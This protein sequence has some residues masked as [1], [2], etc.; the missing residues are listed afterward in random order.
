MKQIVVTDHG[1]PDLSIERDVLESMNIELIDADIETSS[2]M[3]DA[4]KEADALLNQYLSIPDEVL[5]GVDSLKV[6]GRYGIGVDTVNVD[7]ATENGIAVINVPDYCV[8]EVA[9]HALS[10]I[11]ACSRKVPLFDRAVKAGEWEWSIGR[12]IHRIRGSTLGIVAFGNIGRRLAE[13]VEGFDVDIIAF[14][15]YQSDADLAAYGVRK[16]T[17]TELLEQSDFISVHA[18]LTAETE[19]LFDAEAFQAMKN[20]AVL[21]NTSRGAVIDTNALRTAITDEEIAGAGLDVLPSEPPES[22]GLTSLDS[23]VVTPHVAWYSEESIEE[24]R[25]TLAAEVGHYLVEKTAE[26]IVNPSVK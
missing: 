24:L 14:D 26:N 13:L 21:I 16:V 18:P 11:L 6:I 3:L 10:L 8:D 1:F 22:D 23:V 5:E 25:H 4:V 19:G 20:S 7:R 15:P 2:D 17:F 9:T 12:P